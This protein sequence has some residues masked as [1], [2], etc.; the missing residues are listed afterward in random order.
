[1]KTRQ[2]VFTLLTGLALVFPGLAPAQSDSGDPWAAEA[3]DNGAEA[4]DWGDDPWAEESEGWQWYGFVE[5]GY[6][7]RLRS[8]E[9]INE[10]ATLN[11]LRVQLEAERRIGDFD[12]TLKGDVWA[13]GVEDGGR[14]DLREAALSGTLTEQVDV[15]AGRQTLTWGTGDL[16]FLND[17]FPKD[18]VSFFSGRDDEYLKAPSD[19]LRL[20]WY[21]PVN[22]EFVWM[23]V[24]AP[25]RYIEGKRLSYFSPALGERTAAPVDPADRDLLG[26]DSEFALRIHQ[27]VNGT[28]YAGYAYSGYDKQP[29]AQEPNSQT[30][31]FPRLNAFGASVRRPI[32]EGIGNLETAWYDAEDSQGTD[33]NRPNDQLRFLAGFTHEPV[34]NLTLGWQYYLEWTQDHDALVA[35]TPDAQRPYAPDEYRH[36]ITNRITWQ[37]MQQDLTLSLF[38]FVSPSD[39]DYYLRPRARYRFSDRL[40]GT[41]G[42]NLFGGEDEWT[43]HTQLED[44]SNLYAR[45]RY[46]F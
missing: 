2:W 13:D 44:N 15:R 6:A 31:Y 9:A 35:A 5:G 28:E 26:D 45:L 11:E 46:S 8:D 38:S 42:G 41:V 16:V 36:L 20:S 12:A 7:G 32:G 3:P 23:P 34:G 22:V 27:T 17:L 14:G 39:A 10:D 37:G 21:G 40:F 4:D 33:P 1:M 18:Y 19:A 25:N 30:P 29:S 24:A 43:F